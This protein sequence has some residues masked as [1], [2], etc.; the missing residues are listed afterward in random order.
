VTVPVPDSVFNGV[1]DF[2]TVPVTVPERDLDG[3]CDGV[4]NGV[5]DFVPVPERVLDGLCD[6][7]FDGVPDFVPDPE[8]VLDGL[9]DAVLDGVAVGVRYTQMRFAVTVQ[10]D[11]SV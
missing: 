10:G 7:V 5:P 8:R 2:V 1:P 6:G 9:C 11:V 4:F 3:L